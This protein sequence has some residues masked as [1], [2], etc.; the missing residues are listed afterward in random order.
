MMSP[1]FLWLSGSSSSYKASS[2]PPFL[3]QFFSP[4][5]FLNDTRDLPLMFRM[6]SAALEQV[7]K[8]SVGEIVLPFFAL[9]NC[10]FFWKICKPVLIKD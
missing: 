5:I 4:L 2:F 6:F 7:F 8:T 3:I 1:L 10:R 9:Q